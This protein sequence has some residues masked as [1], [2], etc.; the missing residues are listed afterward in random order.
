MFAPLANRSIPL[1]QRKLNPCDRAPA[2]RT[3]SNRA[4]ADSHDP[5]HVVHGEHVTG[6]HLAINPSARVRLEASRPCYWALEPRTPHWRY[7][8]QAHGDG[9]MALF[10]AVSRMELTGLEPVTSWVRSRR[11]ES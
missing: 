6:A 7:T 5:V 4:S 11:Q 9:R 1:P 8:S 10:P 3:L 2:E